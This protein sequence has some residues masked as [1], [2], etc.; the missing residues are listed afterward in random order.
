M[1]DWSKLHDAL[2]RQ[3]DFS[4]LFFDSES[5]T[6]KEKE[7]TLKTFVLSAHSELTGIVDAINYK[8]HRLGSHPVD[9]QKILYKSVD[10]YRYILAILNLWDVSGSAFTTALAQKDDFLHYRHRLSQKKWAGQPVVLFDMDD[11]LAEFRASFCAYATQETGAFIDPESDEYYNTKEFKRLGI[12]GEHYFKSFI[13]LHGFLLLERNQ[14]YY[15]FLKQLQ[16]MGHWVQIVTSRPASNLTAF[17]DTYS[18]LARHG[19]E[20][21]GVTF[22]SEKFIWLSDQEYFSGGDYFAVDDSAKHAAEYAKH[23][24]VVLVPEKSYNKEVIGLP[25]VTYVSDALDPMKFVP[26]RR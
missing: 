21:D 1:T 14:K 6:L 2:L 9:T 8:E 4:R 22:T 16:E 26:V 19:I 13:D 20:A 3:D 5:M 18:W 25:N 10:V 7:E 17:Y 15:D 24:V 23:G 12:K 11:V